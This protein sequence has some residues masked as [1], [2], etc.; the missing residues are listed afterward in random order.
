MGRGEQRRRGALRRGV[1]DD[2]RRDSCEQRSLCCTAVP[3]RGVAALGRNHDAGLL[4]DRRGRQEGQEARR[5]GG[6]QKA[7]ARLLQGLQSRYR[8]SCGAP[9]VRTG[10]GACQGVARRI[11]CGRRAVRRSGHRGRLP[12]R[13]FGVRRRNAGVGVRGPL[14]A[15]TA[16]RRPCG[17]AGAV[18]N[19]QDARIAA[20]AEGG[21]PQLRRRTSSLYRR[22]DAA[23][24][25]TVRGRRTPTSR[26]ALPTGR[27]CPTIRP[28]A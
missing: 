28:T 1:G 13:Q 2:P 11:R 25:P 20:G 15:R 5:S 27:C 6:A 16:R 8:P 12:L 7:A 14:F 3:Q 9:H 23:V 22:V 17:A 10:D 19:G 21:E 24:P 4:R 26:F 18:G